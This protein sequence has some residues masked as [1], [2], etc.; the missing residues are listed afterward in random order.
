LKCVNHLSDF[1]LL[2]AQSK[3]ERLSKLQHNRY[4][5][6][7]V[8]NTFAIN[9]IAINRTVKPTIVHTIVHTISGIVFLQT[10]NS[11]TVRLTD[12]YAIA[13][14]DGS[15]YIVPNVSGGGSNYTTNNATDRG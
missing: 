12:S 2:V 10:N 5:L 6:S 9:T 13:N 11:T 15:T 7:D 8:C 4:L 3:H 14:S 1:L